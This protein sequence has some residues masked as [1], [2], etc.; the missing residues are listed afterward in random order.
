MVHLPP[1][2]MLHVSHV[3][4]HVSHFKC[5]ESNDFFFL[6]FS[7]TVVKLVGGQWGCVINGATPSSSNSFYINT[8]FISNIIQLNSIRSIR[9]MNKI[10]LVNITHFHKKCTWSRKAKCAIFLLETS[11]ENPGIG[12]L[13][14]EVKKSLEAG[15][16]PLTPCLKELVPPGPLLQAS[17]SNLFK[18]RAPD[19]LLQPTSF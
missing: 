19:F 3:T 2:A 13:L 9:E 6:L 15:A 4:C 8:I 17:S 10:T 7:D 16:Q 1:H 14:C 18:L 12:N 5:P 11:S